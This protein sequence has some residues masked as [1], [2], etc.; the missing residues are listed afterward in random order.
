MYFLRLLTAIGAAGHFASAANYTLKVVNESPYSISI[1]NEENEPI[2]SNS[3]L[4]AGRSNDTVT[5][6]GNH[7]NHTSVNA[8]MISP[9][10]A[11]VQIN[12]SL[13]YTGAIFGV[14][15]G[16]KHYGVWGYPW[17]ASLQNTDIAFDLKGLQSDYGVKYSSARS[18]FF[19]SDT[20]YAVY[21]DTMSMGSYSFSSEDQEVQF[22]FNT[23]ELVYYVILPTE[24]GDIK[25]ILKQYASLTDT[26]A[27][28]SPTS[29]GPLFWH[30]DFESESGFPSG[31]NN[32]QEFVQ[33]VVDKLFENR[34][35]ASTIMVDRP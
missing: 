11:R 27:L 14:E 5:A 33:D 28:W 35:R 8:D 4:L 29:Y 21:T 18:P 23:T 30:D 1:S 31:V 19:I 7:S 26:T 22:I 12:S 20:G 16:A 32:S 25:S 34:V 9:T 6:V 17:N 13:G 15:E 24:E 10:I 2:C 3:A